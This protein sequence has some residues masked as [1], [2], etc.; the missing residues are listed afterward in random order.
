MRVGA[1]PLIGPRT[2]KST[3]GWSLR[4]VPPAEQYGNGDPVAGQV[5]FALT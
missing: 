4:S 3:Y 5:L 1:R 2:R